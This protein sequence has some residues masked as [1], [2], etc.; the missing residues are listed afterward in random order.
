[1]VSGALVIL[2]AFLTGNRKKIR[3][4][5]KDRAGSLLAEFSL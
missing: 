1:M 5:S 3:K 4:R 2:F